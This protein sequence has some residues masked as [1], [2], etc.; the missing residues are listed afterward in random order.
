[1]SPWLTSWVVLDE[2]NS[3]MSS[4]KD[5]LLSSSDRAVLSACAVGGATTG[6]GPKADAA[7][8]EAAVEAVEAAKAEDSL[9]LNPQTRRQV[10]KP[11]DSI[12][13]GGM[14]SICR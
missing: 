3:G 14:L 2:T 7:V 6:A 5:P 13:R 9:K 8:N 1:V 4:E 10:V 12:F 11:K